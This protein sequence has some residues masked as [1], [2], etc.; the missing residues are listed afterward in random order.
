M[1]PFP[2]PLTHHSLES[3]FEKAQTTEETISALNNCLDSRITDHVSNVSI[4]LES[5]RPSSEETA[6]LHDTKARLEE[7][8]KYMEEKAA[9]SL[10]Q[11]VDT[12]AKEEVLNKACSDL[13]TQLAIL[14]QQA[15]DPMQI[16][17]QCQ[18][19]TNTITRLKDDIQEK[20]RLLTVKEG[21]V[22]QKEAESSSTQGLVN[23]LRN[24]NSSLETQLASA[25]EE[26]FSADSD[27]QAREESIRS[28]LATENSNY[29]KI[30]ATERE[31]QKK[32]LKR[33]Q[34]MLREEKKKSKVKA[35]KAI[36]GTKRVLE[37]LKALE[38]DTASQMVIKQNR[39]DEVEA[40]LLSMSNERLASQNEAA[41]L[42][43]L[44]DEQRG[45]LES[46]RETCANAMHGKSTIES[47]LASLNEELQKAGEIREEVNRVPLLLEDLKLRDATITELQAQTANSETLRQSL[48]RI[49]GDI[50][51]K[52]EE[53]SSLRQRLGTAESIA[54]EVQSMEASIRKQNDQITNLKREL[55]ASVDTRKKLEEFQHLSQQREREIVD[56]K[57]RLT[58]AQELGSQLVSPSSAVQ[59][60]DEEL[61]QLEKTLES[62]RKTLQELQQLPDTIRHKEKDITDLKHNLTVALEA[63]SKVQQLRKDL[64]D[65]DEGI[66]VLS[67]KLTQRAESD[68]EIAWVRNAL[69]G[70]G[71]EV[72]AL[73]LQLEQAEETTQSVSSL[74]R[75]AEQHA[76]DFLRLSQELDEAKKGTEQMIELKRA[77]EERDQ[78]LSALKKIVAGLS[79]ASEQVRRLEDD[80]DSKDVQLAALHQ[81]LAE[82]AQKTDQIAILEEAVG[83]RDHELTVLKDRL[84]SNTQQSEQIE[85]L[86]TECQIKDSE[87]F[88]LRERL[89]EIE[90]QSQQTQ[91][92]LLH[93]GVPSQDEILSQ[94][95]LTILDHNMQQNATLDPV[96][97]HES[98][99]EVQVAPVRP[100][101][102]ANRDAIQPQ[103]LI[104]S[105]Q[106]SGP[107]HKPRSKA[108]TPPKARNSV[109]ESRHART[110]T[111][112]SQATTFIPDSQ[113]LE[114]NGKAMLPEE[115]PYE[116]PA[117][118]RESSPLTELD[119]IVD[120]SP[121][122]AT[123]GKSSYF[124][125]NFQ[126]AATK[127]WEGHTK[128]ANAAKQGNAYS[129]KAPPAPTKLVSDPQVRD[130]ARSRASGELLGT[131]AGNEIASFEYYE[132]VKVPLN[133]HTSSRR[134]LTARSGSDIYIS[135]TDSQGRTRRSRS[136][137]SKTPVVTPLAD[138]GRSSINQSN[139]KAQPARSILKDT[140]KPN[141][142]AKRRLDSYEETDSPQ[143]GSTKRLRRDL[144]A[145][146]TSTPSVHK[147][148]PNMPTNEKDQLLTN[149]VI[150][151]GKT[152]S[153]KNGGSGQGPT[154][155]SM[156]TRQS[157]RRAS[158]G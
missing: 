14:Q 108:E 118:T 76:Q 38:L 90:Q 47:E 78:E 104:T 54:S 52:E 41:R 86:R 131:E 63:A 115:T 98:T 24:N 121:P 95:T 116:Q 84:A 71:D 140:P 79:Y 37:Q 100:R 25:K 23:D 143:V 87:L 89:A 48:V 65:K 106:D 46:A 83:I 32:Q 105:D 122:K 91:D 34:W 85:V 66:S 69:K 103:N 39:I 67:L 151:A 149:A 128:T 42:R 99:I 110:E 145:L 31:Q 93:P 28:H 35:E 29:R 6:N 150:S 120:S 61:K 1:P 62:T 124:D 132:P 8:L 75:E 113:P 12:V 96:V 64:E 13:R 130:F 11:Y 70:K 20:N 33:T 56:L 68:Q 22:K 139:G 73:R 147:S 59:Q 112:P 80:I 152:Q 109:N 155:S 133:D 2:L 45:N 44:C 156:V 114:G 157:Q 18:E 111:L 17:L 153:R 72:E 154:A 40:L 3:H 102:R 81:E 26:K 55:A 21:E 148:T 101:R 74:Q 107:R 5:L 51:G 138:R 30:F 77:I 142:A 57:E 4:L 43:S 92:M 129:T 141:S 7:R 53:L 117:Q 16:Q 119:E 27:S 50:T 49:R 82:E 94:D 88:L 137:R 15:M 10:Q 127:L 135:E 136:R 125:Q 134:Q 58:A 60:K 97:E 146:Q 158:K 9:T 126:P 144:S 36:Q 19:Y 123:K